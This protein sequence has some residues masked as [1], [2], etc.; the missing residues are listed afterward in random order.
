MSGDMEK[1]EINNLKEWKL[2][3]KLISEG[4]IFPYDEINQIIK[5]QITYRYGFK[6]NP[7]K[8]HIIGYYQNP[9]RA[10][11]NA[12]EIFLHC[13]L[14]C[15]DHEKCA[16]KRYNEFAGSIPKFPSNVGD[17]MFYGV[18]LESDGY[19][20]KIDEVRHFDFYE[21]K[22]CD[23]SKFVYLKNL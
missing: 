5:E 9:K 11:K 19:M 3:Q 16:E 20:S 4:Y 13:S 6:N 18:L 12:D 17:S 7:E 23:M 21:S 8:N 1:K 22:K 2:I 15:Y 10:H 14:S